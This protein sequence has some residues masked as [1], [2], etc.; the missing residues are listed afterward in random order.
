[1]GNRITQRIYECSE[2]GKIPENGEYLW[3]MGSEIWCEECTE[4]E[5]EEE[6]PYLLTGEELEKTEKRAKDK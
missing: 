2:C 3:H 6:N 5:P 4:K 1:M